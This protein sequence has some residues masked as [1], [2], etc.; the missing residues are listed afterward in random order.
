V[1]HLD[2]EGL[3]QD[4]VKEPDMISSLGYLAP[5]F[6]G[7]T[8]AFFWREIRALEEL[9]INS[10]LISTRRPPARIN[11]HGWAA[12]AQARTTYLL[13]LQMRDILAIMAELLRAGPV[14]IARCLK[15]ALT[16]DDCTWAE[17]LRLCIMIAAAAKLARIMRKD[18]IEHLHVQSCANSANLAMF[19]SF[20]SGIPYS[21]S[22][23]GP[24]LELYGPNQRSKWRHA[25]FG[26]VMSKLLYDVVQDRLAGNLP[27]IVEIVPV[28]VDLNEMQRETPYLPWQPG[29]ACRIYSC[30]RLN[31]IKGHDKL[32]EAIMMLRERGIDCHLTIAGEDEQGGTGYRHTLERF[33]A[34][35]GAA[36][37]V[38]LLGAVPE[39]EHRA[40]LAQAHIFALASENEG[41]S[42]AIMESM[43]MQTPVVVTDVGGNSELVVNGD[44]GVLVTY[45]KP[46]E[47]AAAMEKVLRHPGFAL[48][49]S[50]ASRRRVDEKFNATSTARKL[51][52]CLKKSRAGS[53]RGGLSRTAPGRTRTSDEGIES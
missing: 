42:V 46:D 48:D 7:Q 23:L 2:A 40:Q 33:I 28:G 5:E 11:V 36:A 26:V 53:D 39:T 16:A 52:E 15:I 20:L 37:H 10:R 35:R 1:K 6:P 9:G 43:A 22:L 47:M 49:L 34:D 12:Q 18:G 25:A 30:G 21:L 44:N 32:I 50:K 8:H 19:A 24:T 51:F 14:R 41:I 38:T 13:P 27:E 29:E 45:G 31:A 4:R 3:A 17:R